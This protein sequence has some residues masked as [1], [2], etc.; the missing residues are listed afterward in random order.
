MYIGP[1]CCSSM[2]LVSS[3]TFV[4]AIPW[5]SYVCTVSENMTFEIRIFTID[6]LVFL[7]CFRIYFIE[8]IA[9]LHSTPIFC[10]CWQVNPN[11]LHSHSLS[12]SVCCSGWLCGSWRSC[13]C[14]GKSTARA[15]GGASWPLRGWAQV[16]ICDVGCM[17]LYIFLEQK[18]YEFGQQK[19]T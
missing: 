5:N 15:H 10:Q 13:P 2:L 17:K 8:S 19:K 11:L 18:Q 3:P 12:E 14:G 6:I 16:L 4:G 7:V 1:I 9:F